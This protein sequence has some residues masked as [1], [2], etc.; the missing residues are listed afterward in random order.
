MQARLYVDY[1]MCHESQKDADRKNQQA[2][3]DRINQWR[4]KNA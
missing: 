4:Q 3:I 2:K 1:M